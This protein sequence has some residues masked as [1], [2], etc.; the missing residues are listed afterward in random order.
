MTRIDRGR[1][2]DPVNDTAILQSALDLLIERGATGTSIEGV[3]RHAGVAK[4]T[5]YRRWKTKEDLLMA[6]MEFA[7]TDDLTPPSPGQSVD[8]LVE[9]VAELLSRPRFRT[10]MTRVIGASADYPKLM[11]AYTEHYLAPRLE[12]LIKTAREAIDAGRFP[13]GTDPTVIQD[14]LS[15]AIGFV[16]IHGADVTADQVVQ[17]LHILLKELGYRSESAS[18]ATEAPQRN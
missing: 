13:P 17:R 9:F 1:P 14:V 15:S 6:A 16:L 8:E 2:R 7:R 12:G 18:V 3:A 10:L 11:T 4:L 5:V